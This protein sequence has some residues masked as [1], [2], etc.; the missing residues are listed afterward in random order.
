MQT[1]THLGF[2]Q[3]VF[4]AFLQSRSEPDW[5]REDRRHAWELFEQLDWPRR[6]EEEWIR[7]DIRMFKLDRYAAPLETTDH[8]AIPDGLLCQGIELAGQVTSVNSRQAHAHLA[9]CWAEKGV[10]FG[11]TSQLLVNHEELLKPWLVEHLVDPS[12]DKFT[13]LHTAFRTG[14]ALLYVPRG[15][16]VDQPLHIS[17]VVT[18]YASD[19]S[20]ILVIIEDG[21]AATLLCE[22][23]GIDGS[24]DGLHCGATEIFV[25]RGGH[26]RLVNLQDW[27]RRTW[28]FAH[29]KAVLEQDASLQWTTAALGSQLAKVNQT[30]ELRGPGANC[31]VNG[32]LFT[33]GKQHIA[34][35][36]LQHHIAP[37]CQSDFLYKSALQD[38]SRTVWRGM[39]KVDHDAQQTDGYQRND[40]L[41]LGSGVRAD[42][43][44]GLAIEADDVRCSHG[45]TS[46]RID[47]ELIFYA[48]SRGFTRD[49]AARMIV[50]GF[51]QQI[52]DRITIDTVR[53]SLSQAIAQRVRDY[54]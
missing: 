47:D 31:Q 36:T 32:V 35:N 44:P 50:T 52:F 27:G 15:V 3:N 18:G 41:L 13:A 11:S 53:D 42:S 48:Q 40:N 51:F 34:F 45:S 39:I 14:G 38:K 25:Q 12:H 23:S 19:F 5:L 1:T 30:V 49:E 37:G 26:L 8:L 10:L 46:G 4:D 21:A 54:V 9:P 24:D 17:S 7:T 20:H 43:I 28:H 16:S 33:Q 29:Q 22:S 2:D 6:N